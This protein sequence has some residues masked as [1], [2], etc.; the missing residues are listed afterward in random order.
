MC[1]H[2]AIPDH[3]TLE[4]FLKEYEVE[5]PEYDTYFH[6]NAFNHP[7]IPVLTSEEPHKIQTY[8]WGLAPT[9]AKDRTDAQNWA[10]QMLN[11]TCEKSMTTY[12]P[13]FKTKRC[14]VFVNGF[15][16]WRW[17]DPKGKVKT[18]YFI[19]A[20]GRQPFTF[21]GIYNN[22]ADRESGQVFDTFSIVTTPANK[23]MEEIHNN[24]KRM[25]LIVSQQEWG[26]W[27]DPDADSLL[28]CS[29]IQTVF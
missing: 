6:A 14:L 5:V 17:E 12:R 18:P 25:P 27:L 10:K 16:E 24:K 23:L 22:W 15:Y 4:Q 26:R 7:Q 2:V 11:A 29:L 21:G 28:Y 3:M 8:M 9:W 13:Y 20:G 1:N 19:Y